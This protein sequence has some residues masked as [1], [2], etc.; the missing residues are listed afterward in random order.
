MRNR[1][2]NAF[3]LC[4][5]IAA[6]VWLGNLVFHNRLGGHV[7]NGD[8]SW[9]GS[10][11]ANGDVTKVIN[12]SGSVWGGTAELVEEAA[13]GVGDG[14][15]EY[16]LGGNVG[17]AATDERIYIV[18][19]S[20]PAVRAYDYE[21]RHLL[22]IGGRGQGPG[23]F[24]NPRSVAV[25]ADARV[26]VF[27]D[28]RINVFSE[29]G[30]SLDTWPHATTLDSLTPPVVANDGTLY[31]ADLVGDT[32]DVMAWR[33]GMTP[34]GPDGAAGTT[35]AVPD[36]DYERQ[37][38]MQRLPGGF[39]NSPVPFTPRLLWVMTPARSMVAGVPREYS[40]EIH[41]FD[42]SATLVKNYWEPVPVSRE[43]AE[44]TRE[45]I[46]FRRRQEDPGWKWN[47]PPI[48]RHKPAYEGLYACAEGRIWVARVIGTDRVTDCDE[49]PTRPA[50]RIA[51]S[52]W[53]QRYGY[54]VFDAGGNRLSA[55][56]RD[57]GRSGLRLR[58]GR[59]GDRPRQ[60]LSSDDALAGFY[61]GQRAISPV[62]PGTLVARPASTIA[63]PP[64][65]RDNRGASHA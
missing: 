41:A 30:K 26:Y 40:F 6:A 3:L 1:I 42:G 19:P 45:W 43:E 52:C 33:H 47:G 11:D 23:E 39:L 56:S 32:F 57:P 7:Q 63:A 17:I 49:D 64:F 25:S 27:A 29:E 14:A 16:M 34:A 44:W 21:G 24:M 51:R 50:G 5:V 55:E 4:M 58:R 53:Q 22:D 2:I 35:I 65:A 61:H 60:T 10:V 13:I 8:A 15:A 46:T 31:V 59:R 48:P 36:L 62:A 37:G 18:D 12:E 20:V 54:D 28:L 9:Q 38:L